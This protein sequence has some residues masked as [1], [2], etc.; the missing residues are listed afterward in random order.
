MT[1]SSEGKPPWTLFLEQGEHRHVVRMN[2]EALEVDGSP[3]PWTDV[4]EIAWTPSEVRVRR[5]G[6]RVLRLGWL[7]RPDVVDALVA[8]LQAVR[9]GR[10]APTSPGR[11]QV[12]LD[13]IELGIARQDHIRV[14][15]LGITPDG[16]T[17]I[18]WAHGDL[19]LHTG[20]EQ[21]LT[22][23]LGDRH[24]ADGDGLRLEWLRDRILRYERPL[25]GTPDAEALEDLHDL[26][27]R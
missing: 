7:L 13:H 5:R 27:A 14:D 2:A 18:P 19:A 3:T 16:G 22:L 8:R 23:R 15:P 11:E 9:E 10:P 26:R 17:R 6:A 1:A 4:I 12:H 25:T 24:V 20:P 21:P